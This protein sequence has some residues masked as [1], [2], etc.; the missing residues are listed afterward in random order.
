MW[1][2]ILCLLGAHIPKHSEPKSWHPWTTSKEI[3]VTCTKCDK[4][5]R[6]FLVNQEGRDY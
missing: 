6:K 4:V 5:I 3:T 2:K 1:S